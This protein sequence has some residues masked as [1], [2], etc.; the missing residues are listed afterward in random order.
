[1]D[2]RSVGTEEV[3]PTDRRAHL[4]G[5][6]FEQGGLSGPVRSDNSPPTPTLNAQGHT[7]DGR[8]AAKA[9]RDVVD[10]KNR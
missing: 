6:G 1:M 10:V 2:S 9:D 5:N 4:S 7:V 3:H 8:H